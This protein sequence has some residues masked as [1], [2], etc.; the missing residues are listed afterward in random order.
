MLSA[1]PCFKPGCPGKLLQ[2]LLLVIII[3]SNKHIC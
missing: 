1:V 2:M 3:D